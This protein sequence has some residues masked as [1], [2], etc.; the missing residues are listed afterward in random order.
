M[1]QKN[2]KNTKLILIKN[3]RILTRTE[4]SK[5]KLHFSSNENN[6]IYQTPKPQEK[7]TFKCI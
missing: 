7:K 2:E 6:F 5:Q 1:S 4:L 3:R